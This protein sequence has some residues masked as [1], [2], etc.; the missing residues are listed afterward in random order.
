M[1]VGIT[2]SVVVTIVGITELVGRYVVVI[3]VGITELDFPVVVQEVV[4]IKVGATLEVVHEV[5][6]IGL[7]LMAVAKA[8]TERTL[9]KD[10]IF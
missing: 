2:L 6:L 4:V 5:E 3:I 1:I 8:A 7:A 9:I 10:F